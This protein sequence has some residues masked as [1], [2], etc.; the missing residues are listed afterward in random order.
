MKQSIALI[1][2]GNER[3]TVG[4]VH[5]LHDQRSELFAKCSDIML[6]GFTNI[7]RSQTLSL[8]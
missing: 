7:D 1:K 4:R 8:T 3:L 2:N 6:Y 5:A